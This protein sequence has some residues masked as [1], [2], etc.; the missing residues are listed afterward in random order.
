MI[1]QAKSSKLTVKEGYLVCPVCKR[2][3]KLLQIDPATQAKHLVVYC[4]DCKSEIIVDIDEG[5]CFE[6]RC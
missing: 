2:N 3:R 1:C 5:Q 4:R 6:S